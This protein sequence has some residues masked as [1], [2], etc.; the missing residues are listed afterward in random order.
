MPRHKNKVAKLIL[1]RLLIG[2]AVIV[3]AQSPYFWIKFYDNLFKGKPIFKRQARNSFYYLRKRGLI[4]IE[5]KN[6]NIYMFLTKEGEK[7]AG[8]YQLNEMYIKKPKKWD[9]KWRLII[10]DIPE[11][12]RIKR[13][14]FRGKLKELGFYQLQ[15]SVWVYPYSC[16]KEINLLRDF[17]GLKKKN[18]MALTVEKIES[19]ENL[20]KFFNL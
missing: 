3:A 12:H 8:R 6:K 13:D 7:E 10:F 19:D 18:L 17:F 14:L 11:N 20:R 4:R 2:G 5:K 16:Q 9:K 1:R 15:K